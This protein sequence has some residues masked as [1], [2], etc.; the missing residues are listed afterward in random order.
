MDATRIGHFERYRGGW[1]VHC[2]ECASGRK[3]PPEGDQAAMEMQNHIQNMKRDGRYGKRGSDDR[4]QEDETTEETATVKK[5][6][7]LPA[8][9]RQDRRGDRPPRATS[10]WPSCARWATRS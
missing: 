9:G 10:P 5:A 6:I 3:L 7:D 4:D 2:V 1:R 8:H